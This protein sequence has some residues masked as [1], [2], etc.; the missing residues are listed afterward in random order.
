MAKKAGLHL[1]KRFR[2]AFK[3]GKDYKR[4]ILQFRPEHS[5]GQNIEEATVTVRGKDD[6]WSEE[7]LDLTREYYWDDIYEEWQQRR[8]QKLAARP[9]GGTPAV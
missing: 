8:R 1:C 4:T 5:E 9:A 2:I 3:D 6:D 7:F